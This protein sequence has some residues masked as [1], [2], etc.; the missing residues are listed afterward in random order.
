M[1]ETIHLRS[2]TVS[3]G[4][5][6]IGELDSAYCEISTLINYTV[7]LQYVSVCNDG[8]RIHQL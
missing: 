5:L 1:P 3:V 2:M 8:N 7:F 6:W 4:F